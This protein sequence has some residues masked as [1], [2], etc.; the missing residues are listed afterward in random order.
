M[1]SDELLELLQQ[2]KARRSD[3]DDVPPKFIVANQRLQV[4]ELLEETR[5]DLTEQLA[6]VPAGDIEKVVRLCDAIKAVEDAL[7]ELEDPDADATGTPRP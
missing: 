5:E 2:A 3:G 7:S 6:E 1:K 4:R